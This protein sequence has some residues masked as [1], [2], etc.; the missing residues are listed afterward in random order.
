MI[1]NWNLEL[2][3]ELGLFFAPNWEMCK[4][5]KKQNV[6]VFYIFLNNFEDRALEKIEQIKAIPVDNEPGD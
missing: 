2:V 3:L 5:M 6:S 4:I 1:W